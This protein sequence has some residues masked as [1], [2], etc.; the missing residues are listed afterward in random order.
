M[1]R[2]I[3][4]ILFLL[5]LNLETI[6]AH[7]KSFSSVNLEPISAQNVDRL[8]QIAKI[9]TSMG[10]ISQIAWSPDGTRLA[11]LG[12]VDENPMVEIRNL[13]ESDLEDP[14]VEIYPPIA[15]H[16]EWLPDG[17]S[18]V[19]QGSGFDEGWAHFSAVKWDTETGIPLETLLDA[20]IE[21][22]AL[23]SIQGEKYYDLV[24]SP[25]L[26]WNRTYTE[27]ANIENNQTISFTTGQSFTINYGERER[28]HR[29]QWSPD[30]SL[31]AIVYGGDD[32]Y[33]IEIVEAQTL[34]PQLSAMGPDYFV[35]EIAWSPDNSTLAVASIWANPFSPY[36]NVRF[37]RI[38]EPVL[39]GGEV[40][41]SGD[42]EDESIHRSASLA[43]SPDNNVIGISFPTTVSLYE[44]K[45]FTAIHSIAESEIAS[46]SWHPSNILIAGGRTDGTL[47]LWGIPE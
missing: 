16:L 47:Y 28:I 20:Q 9:S 29:I 38:G 8:Q 45:A 12:T 11:I 6:Q 19:T 18:I 43:W 22:P 27:S 42:I 44:T 34:E 39:Y 32:T 25:I 17:N 4:L 7:S 36:V 37:Y 21:R 31:I 30:N 5:L 14:S 13:S 26:G 41:L 46:L 10:V 1:L 3:T 23:G 15:Q 24:L 35:S 2:R 33:D 40:I